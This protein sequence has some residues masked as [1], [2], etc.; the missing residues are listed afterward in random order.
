V[1]TRLIRGFAA[2]LA[3]TL[4]SCQA[5]YV[6]KEART[7]VNGPLPSTLTAPALNLAAANYD[8]TVTVS[9][10]VTASDT[11]AVAAMLSLAQGLVGTSLIRSQTG[12]PSTVASTGLAHYQPVNSVY[13]IE[14]GSWSLIY[15]SIAAGTADEETQNYE[16]LSD[17]Y[18][19]HDGSQSKIFKL[20]T[21]ALYR[22]FLDYDIRYNDGTVSAVGTVST[23]VRGEWFQ[24]INATGA[25]IGTDPTYGVVEASAGMLLGV[26]CVDKGV[27]L[28]GKI[29]MTAAQSLPYTAN[30][31]AGGVYFVTLTYDIQCYDQQ[32]NLCGS[33]SVQGV[34]SSS[35]SASY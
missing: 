19:A 32:G 7:T 23:K 17:D 34:T 27:T 13:D 5:P 24:D 15:N 1:K 14:H 6:D 16:E 22:D 30:S 28:G 29:L 31:N 2:A 25:G 8:S 12:T 33:V 35:P 21:H 11:A 4:L 3:A 9:R 18:A 10:S 26:T 20:G